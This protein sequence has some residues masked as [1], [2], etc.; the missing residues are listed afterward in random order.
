MRQAQRALYKQAD[1]EVESDLKET[2]RREEKGKGRRG[3]EEP[4]GERP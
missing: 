4:K 3:R 2:P 1:S